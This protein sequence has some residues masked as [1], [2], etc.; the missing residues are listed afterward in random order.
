[1]TRVLMTGVT[2]FLGS[3]LAANMLAQGDSLL[4]WVRNDADGARTRKAVQ[5]AADG[6]GLD[7]GHA[8][9]TRLHVLSQDGAGGY[10]GADLQGLDEV[11]YAWHVAAEMSYSP[12]RL[13]QCFATNVGNTG[14]LYQ[15][16]RRHAPAC[17][18]MFYVSTAYVAGLQGGHVREE[19][20]PQAELINTYQSSK[21]AAEMALQTLQSRHGLPVSIVRP[22]GV[23]GHRQSGWAH[24]NG[25]GFYLFLNAMQA[26]ARAGHKRL[27]VDLCAW[28]RPDL[29]AI[30]ELVADALALCR[31]PSGAD[32]EVFHASGGLQASVAQIVRVWGET[33]GVDAVLGAP[34][35]EMEQQ[36]DRAV[37]LNRPFANQEWQFDRSGLNQAVGLAHSRAPLSVD[38]IARLSA[39]FVGQTAQAAR[40]GAAALAS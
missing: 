20:H 9:A 33:T 40:A 16:L 31:R 3:A 7:I 18:R 26:V 6:F 36:F 12:Q 32:F 38:D 35:S 1:M 5:D 11:E 13:A 28:S 15:Q 27:H 4:A 2:G 30:D 37:G 25:F 14:A 39:W 17:K 10:S 19:L 23:V 21:W 34:V 8:L 24:R 29:V 22:T